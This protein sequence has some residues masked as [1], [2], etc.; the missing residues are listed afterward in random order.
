MISFCKELTHKS[1]RKYE[2]TIE[3]WVKEKNTRK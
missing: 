2:Y 1:L 3:K